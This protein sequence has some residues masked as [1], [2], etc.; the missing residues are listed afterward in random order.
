MHL[1]PADIVCTRGIGFLARAIQVCQ[2]AP[3]EDKSIINHVGLI[4][5]AGTE[6]T[7]W[8]IE[9]LARGT[10]EHSFDR[11]VYNQNENSVCVLRNNM[12]TEDQRTLVVNKARTYVGRKY[13]YLK[14]LAHAG[15]YVIGG[16]YFFRKLCRMDNYPICSWAISHPYEV[17]NYKFLDLD[18]NLAQPDDIW[19]H[20]MG[21]LG[22]EWSVVGTL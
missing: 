1:L 21:R 11:Y 16:K 3:G 13:G 5:R 4:S 2:R 12:L 8:L 22:V 18:A 9:S 14:I 10:V 6:F 17:V 15:D 7:A 20:S 19:D